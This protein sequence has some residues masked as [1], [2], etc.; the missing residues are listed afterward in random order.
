M[1]TPC[2]VVHQQM[3][4]S[5][6]PKFWK[7]TRKF[8]KCIGNDFNP[9]VSY[10]NAKDGAPEGWAPSDADLEPADFLNITPEAR[11]KCCLYINAFN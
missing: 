1:R 3:S 5:H 10:R 4:Q 6:R 11:A 2:E 9:L 8:F 7:N